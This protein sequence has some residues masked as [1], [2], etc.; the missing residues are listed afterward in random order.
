MGAALEDT[1]EGGANLSGREPGTATFRPVRPDDAP[2]LARLARARW[3][4]LPLPELA[5]LQDRAQ[6]SEYSARYGSFGEHVIV[7]DG[8][9]LGRVWW[10]DDATDRRIVDIALL[11]EAQGRG[12]GPAVVASLVAGA[13][14]R[15]TRLSVEHSNPRWRSQLE[16][17]GFVE[18]SSDSVRAELV[19]PPARHGEDA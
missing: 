6:R 12:T 1:G 17:M 11:P 9:P 14:N 4:N 2:L 13:G 10:S 8:V 5:E 3:S 18:A 16:A 19:R 7:V 15:S